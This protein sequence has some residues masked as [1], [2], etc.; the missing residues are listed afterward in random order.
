MGL[1]LEGRPLMAD[2]ELNLSTVYWEGAVALSGTL[3]GV[4]IDARGY[5]KMT[6]YAGSMAGRL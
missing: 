3:D 4:P 5:I 6:G 2:Q 1:E